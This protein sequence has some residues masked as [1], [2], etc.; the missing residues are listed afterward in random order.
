MK[1]N[2]KIAAV[3]LG[4]NGSTGFP[5]KNTMKILNKPAYEYAINAAKNSKY[6]DKIFFSTDI[7]EIISRRKE[8]GLEII[9]RPKHLLTSQALFED[10]VE[11]AYYEIKNKLGNEL[12]YIVILMANAVTINNKLIDEAIEKLELDESADSAVTVSVYNMYSPLRARKLDADGF[13]K[14][15]VPF[16][17]FGDEINLSCDRNSQGDV[18]YADM[19]HSV[20]KSRCIENMKYGLLP[21]KWM[22]NKILPILN[23]D[24]CDID[25]KWQLDMSIR[26]I[27]ENL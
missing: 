4:R 22:G 6:I 10:A 16:S 25:E 12:K 11:H 26:W 19:S 17:A 9:E 5:G 1:I 15:F 27:E 13:L 14:P 21:Q 18:F 2:G 3:I 20:C 23:K 7:S 8:L 24:G